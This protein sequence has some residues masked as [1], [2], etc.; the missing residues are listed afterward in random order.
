MNRLLLSLPALAGVLLVTWVAGLRSGFLLLLGLGFGA[1]LSGA[2]FGF[3]TG[4][5]N[6]IVQKDPWG[7]VAQM[8][9]LA[10]CSV[11]AFPLLHSS[12]DEIV[13]AVSPVTWALLLGAVLFGFAMQ[14]ADGCGSGT[15]YKAGSASPISWAVLPAFVAG[16]FVGASHQPGWESLGGP[17][18]Q[19]GAAPSTSAIDLLS[20]FGLS[21]ALLLTVLGCLAI[22]V[23][24]I[25]YSR[26]HHRKHG[27]SL[28]RVPPRW[29]WG[30]LFLALLYAAHL[31]IAGQPWGIVYG[32]GLWGAK[33]VTAVGVD[34][35][36][37]QFW[38]SAPH[39]SRI[40]EPVL[41]DMTSVTN[42]GLL[43]GALMASRWNLKTSGTTP[44]PTIGQLA[45]SILA[46]LLMGYASR[47]A[48]GC[49]VGAYLGGIASASLHGWIWLVFAFLGS[50]VGVRARQ[51]VGLA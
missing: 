39:T 24:S 49:N 32:L 34:L 14:L 35:S 8:V 7:M 48:Y 15:L 17:L 36:Q 22:A 43:Y 26:L 5:R 44:L 29:L 6:L 28:P 37:N 51:K 21:K 31:V 38:G 50:I 10:L 13:G 4:W 1:A 23:I 11:L 2:K 20:L 27:R 42:I 12:P 33:I 3:T 40:V 9:L 18:L 19:Q 46:G 16:S 45:V 25:L 30:A 41:W 47:M